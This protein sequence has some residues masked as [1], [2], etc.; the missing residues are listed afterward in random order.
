MTTAHDTAKRDRL[1]ARIPHALK[2]RLERAAA[3]EGTRVSEF[4]TRHLFE[5]VDK[6]I[7]DH[8][9]MMLTEADTA[10]FVEAVLNPPAPNRALSD[11]AERSRRLTGE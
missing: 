10:R 8:E 7:Q 1:E 2:Q 11:A 5:A 3:L 9:M 4:V 6:V